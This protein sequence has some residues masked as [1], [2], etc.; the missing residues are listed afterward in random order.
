MSK[1]CLVPGGQPGTDFEVIYLCIHVCLNIGLLGSGSKIISADW[2]PLKTD[3]GGQL[4]GGQLLFLIRNLNS[5][6]HQTL[7]KA[8]MKAY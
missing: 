1:K 5:T 2:K 7:I 4:L 6:P 8:C 3:P